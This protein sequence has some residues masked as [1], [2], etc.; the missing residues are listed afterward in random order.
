MIVGGYDLHLYCDTG[1][2]KPDC[3]NMVE[4]H[5]YDYQGS[6]EIAGHNER[7]AM[8]QAREHGWTFKAGGFV[9]CP[10]CSKARKK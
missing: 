6:T 3:A 2:T 7:D 9:Y 8:K 4:P 1:N 10:R 5:T